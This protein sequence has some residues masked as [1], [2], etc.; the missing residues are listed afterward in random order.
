MFRKVPDTYVNP[1]QRQLL[2]LFGLRL[3]ANKMEAEDFPG[4]PQTVL[5]FEE[6]Q[7]GGVG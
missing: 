5:T 1:N 6:I 3:S 2:F 7:D 4:D